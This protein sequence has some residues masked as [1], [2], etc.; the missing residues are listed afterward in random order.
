MQQLVKEWVVMTPHPHRKS[1]IQ[2]RHRIMM[3]DVLRHLGEKR[4]DAD[5]EDES[6]G[7]VQRKVFAP[8]KSAG[9]EAP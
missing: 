3:D 5:A 4:K 6:H 2:P 7:E 1:Q 9:D 8:S